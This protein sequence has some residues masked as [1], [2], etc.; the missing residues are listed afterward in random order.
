MDVQLEDQNRINEYSKLN[1]RLSEYELE[2]K[3]LTE[4]KED[5]DDVE[6]ELELAD[7]DEK[8]MYKVGDSLVYLPQTEVL[9]RLQ[10]EKEQVN[11]ELDKYSALQSETS[12]RME[13]LK[14]KLYA[15]FGRENINL[16]RD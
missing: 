11:T 15:K 10:T 9:E 5:L 14:T 2:V 13:E 3:T 4:K 16:E 7:E 8:F 6:M 12:D 1:T